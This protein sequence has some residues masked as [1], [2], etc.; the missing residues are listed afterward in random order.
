VSECVSECVCVC[1]FSFPCRCGPLP[2]SE[3]SEA[4]ISVRHHRCKAC[5]T[6]V[7]R[8]QKRKRKRK[9]EEESKE[10]KFAKRL[11][12]SAALHRRRMRRRWKEELSEAPSLATV[13]AI[14]AFRTGP[15][16]SG[17]LRSDIEDGDAEDGELVL[18][19]KDPQGPMSEENHLLLST[20]QS[21]R[22]E[23]VKR[24]IW[25]G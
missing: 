4:V 12:E 22:R 18:R 7:R 21:V 9:D 14:V 19:W 24:D 16:G 17:M 8:E 20:R 10:L 23:C 11:R 15:G 3:F 5:H 25:C 2:L 1:V 13:Q 6:E